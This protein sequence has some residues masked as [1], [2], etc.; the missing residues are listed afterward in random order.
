MQKISN[1]Q[2]EGVQKVCQI[3]GILRKTLS[4]ANCSGIGTISSTP[5]KQIVIVVG[6]CCFIFQQH[7]I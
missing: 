6:F 5:Q 1:D 7:Y 3:E 2:S 4:T